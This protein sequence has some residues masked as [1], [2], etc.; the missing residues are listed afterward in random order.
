MSEKSSEKITVEDLLHAT[1]I[2]AKVIS[3]YG[4]VYLPIFKRLHT[5]LEKAQQQEAEKEKWMRLVNSY[6]P[7]D[8]K[9]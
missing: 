3:L 6:L 2:A 8:E 1:K 5:E 4:D 9:K 7:D